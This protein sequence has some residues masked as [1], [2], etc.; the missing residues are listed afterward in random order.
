MDMREAHKKE[1]GAAQHH[2]RGPARGATHARAVNLARMAA[3]LGRT[4]EARRHAEEA[5]RLAPATP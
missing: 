5:A 3:R 1:A 4:D 2:D